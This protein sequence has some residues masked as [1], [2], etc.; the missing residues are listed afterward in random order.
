MNKA[1]FLVLAGDGINCERESA[2]AIE[3]AGG[4][5]LI[6]HI[7]DLIENPGMLKNHQGLI[8]PG[9]F[10]F[11]DELGSG[12]ILATKIKHQLSDHF[13]EF[14]E[15]KHPILGICNGFQVLTKLGLLPFPFEARGA[16]LA[17]NTSGHFKNLWAQMTVN[18]TTACKWLQGLNGQKLNLPVRHGEGRLLFA[19]SEVEAR[20][21]EL[22]LAALTYDEDING[23]TKQI[24]G[25]TDPSGMILGMMPHPEAFI[26]QA[27]A[28]NPTANHMAA[29]DGAKIFAAMMNYLRAS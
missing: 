25:L 19:D 22:S 24:A 9:G 15:K 12:L 7:N 20:V 28:K 21:M 26:F 8:I 17:H 5:A 3:N 11:G 6:V 29:G 1:M 16:A 18:E 4:K 23:S 14:V 27:T 13:L 2:R 10:S